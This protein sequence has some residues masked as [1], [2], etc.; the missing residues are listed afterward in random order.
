MKKFIYLLAALLILSAFL[1][2]KQFFAT[3]DSLWYVQFE[4]ANLRPR[5]KDVHN[6]SEALKISTG[7]NIKV[8]II[9]KYF[10][11]KLHDNIYAGGKVFD[12]N[13]DAFN[14]IDEHGYWMATTLRELAPDVEIYALGC[15][16][17]GQDQDV[18]AIEKAI[19]WAIQNS[20][21]ILSYSAEMFDQKHIPLLNKAVDK[22]I[23]NGIVICFIHYSH[24]ENILPYGLMTYRPGDY[25]REPD[26]RVLHYDFNLLLLSSYQKYIQNGR[27]STSGDNIPYFS[28]SSMS[29]VVS[30]TVALIMEQHPGL[31]PEEYKKII[32]ASSKEYIY[33]S[34]S[35]HKVLD[36][37]NALKYD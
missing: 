27:K 20:I 7:K 37:T 34:K 19:D 30:A 22:A 21:D 2:V 36:M 1:N 32:T 13:E 33:N 10:G 9:D 4:N 28:F 5:Y 14:N 6:V 25:Q 35:F 3:F 18:I 31:K 15:L 17:D 29:Q 8:G 16:T 12:A 26:I 24:P 11:Y 23:E